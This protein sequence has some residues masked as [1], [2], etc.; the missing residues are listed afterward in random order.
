MR[1]VASQ[2]NSWLHTERWDDDIEALMAA[3]LGSGIQ[4]LVSHEAGATAR[5]AA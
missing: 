2:Y 4:G 1:G 3:Y 5:S